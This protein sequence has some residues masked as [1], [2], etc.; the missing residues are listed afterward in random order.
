MQRQVSPGFRLHSVQA[1]ATDHLFVQL[2]KLSAYSLTFTGYRVYTSFIL[3]DTNVQRILNPA[4]SQRD[5]GRCYLF[6]Y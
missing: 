4:E 5:A 1:Q 6:Q 3:L 2:T